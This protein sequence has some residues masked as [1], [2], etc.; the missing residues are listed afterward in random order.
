MKMRYFIIVVL[1]IFF[2]G[3]F[4]AKLQGQC[5]PGFV[6]TTVTHEIT[7]AGFGTDF[8]TFDFPQFNP[9]LG[10]LSDVS[11]QTSITLNFGFYFE[12]RNI[13]AISRNMR[14]TRMDDFSSAAL[15]AQSPIINNPPIYNSGIKN[16]GPNDAVANSGPD[17]YEMPVTAILN[18]YT[19]TTTV[20]D[21]APF[22]GTGNVSF[23]YNSSTFNVITNGSTSNIATSNATDDIIT[24]RVTY[25]YCAPM[26]VP[27]TVK[28]FTLQKQSDER[29]RLSWLIPNDA[30]G[31]EYI[32][33]KSN[34]GTNFI[35]AGTILYNQSLAGNYSFIYGI[36]PVDD[37]YLLFR[38]KEINPDGSYFYSAIRSI[39]LNDN[40]T[41]IK[42]YPT[43]VNDYVQVSMEGQSSK[44]VVVKLLNA[45]GQVLQQQRANSNSITLNFE[46]RLSPGMYIVQI[47]DMRTRKQT[48]SKIFVR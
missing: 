4:N 26:I 7:V 28:N 11:L 27:S 40:K 13:F 20:A 44:D 38:I 39:L 24:F 37:G 36:Q 45:S 30:H 33:E 6:S 32:V 35:Q 10:T 41:G 18:N 8:Y 47:T 48:V 25:T 5:L 34:D 31:K 21:I 29:L 9:A 22:M 23:D 17:Y 19:Q 43:L 3:S 42:V 2:S 12:N 14:V 1:L 46:K 15:G 16:L